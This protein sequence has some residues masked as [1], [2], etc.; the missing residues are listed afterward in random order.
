MTVKSL[1][2]GTVMGTLAVGAAIEFA[3]QPEIVERIEGDV[4]YVEQVDRHGKKHGEQ[5]IYVSGT[6]SAV[7]MFDR[8][9]LL[10]STDYWPDGTV[11]ATRDVEF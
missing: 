8:G 5:R 7:R 4:R 6:L 10:Q 1:I 2:A 11:R 3:P 9:Y